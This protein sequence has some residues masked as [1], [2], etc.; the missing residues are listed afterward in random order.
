MFFVK[1]GQ[2]EARIL[3]GQQRIATVA[4]LLSVLYDLLNFVRTHS[5]AEQRTVDCSGSIHDSL[6]ENDGTQRVTLGTK[7][8]AVFG[9]L[10][11]PLDRNVVRTGNPYEKL[12]AVRQVG[13]ARK[14]NRLLRECYKFFLDSMVANAPRSTYDPTERRVPDEPQLAGYIAN[15]DAEHFLTTVFD[16]VTRCFYIIEIVTRSTDLVYE[17]FETINQ[18]GTKLYVTDLFKNLIF[19]KFGDRPAYVNSLETQ[20]EALAD[21]A[22]IDDLDVFLR[23]YWLSRYESVRQNKLFRKL[24]EKLRDMDRPAFEAFMTEITSERKLYSLVKKP[25]DTH[26]WDNHDDLR[27]M[28]SELDFLGFRQGLPILLVAYKQSIGG[29]LADFR[30][31]VKSYL[32]YSVRA[33]TIGGRNPNELEKSYG[34]WARELRNGGATINDICQR[35][36]SKTPNNNSIRD[37]IIHMNDVSSRTGNYLWT[38]VNDANAA[39]AGK[40]WWNKVRTVEHVIPQ[41]KDRWWEQYLGQFGMAQEDFVD[42]LGN[43]TVLSKTE[44]SSLGTMQYQSKK[45]RI[46]HPFRGPPLPVNTRTFRGRALANFD[47]AAIEFRERKLLQIVLDERLWTPTMDPADPVA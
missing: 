16:A 14:S 19:E 41:S 29:N 43:L 28:L 11:R 4:I 24:R 1:Q 3:D 39:P 25:L 2:E 26:E 36:I 10:I 37:R 9:A 8:Q 21:V 5:D 27:H 20:W 13:R 40:T 17:M 33:Y 35:F 15:R 23:H 42:R 22:D 31:L 34:D 46:L 47:R 12:A 44:N 32:N 45:Q 18:R 38:M 7:N 6:F 30:R